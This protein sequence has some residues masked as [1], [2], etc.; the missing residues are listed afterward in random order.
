M[1]KHSTEAILLWS[2]PNPNGG[3]M[4]HVWLLKNAYHWD[5]NPARGCC[6]L[7]IGEAVKTG[8]RASCQGA[9][10]LQRATACALASLTVG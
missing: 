6:E 2:Y 5:A 3:T 8:F 9:G 7:G 1:V 10:S 4:A